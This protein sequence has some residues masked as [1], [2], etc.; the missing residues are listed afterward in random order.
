MHKTALKPVYVN[1]ELFYIFAET[2][3]LLIQIFI[4]ESSNCVYVLVSDVFCLKVNKIDSTYVFY[5]TWRNI[6]NVK[7]IQLRIITEF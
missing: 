3:S 7:G 4:E 6:W 5:Q 2:L 1:S